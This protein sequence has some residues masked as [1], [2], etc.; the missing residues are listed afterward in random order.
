MSHLFHTIYKLHFQYQ[1]FLLLE[2][3]SA[4]VYTGNYKMNYTNNIH[5]SFFSELHHFLHALNYKRTVI[6]TKTSD[7]YN[8]LILLISYV[9]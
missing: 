9:E 5:F 1:H 8:E 2:K 6:K 4:A 3:K 7:F